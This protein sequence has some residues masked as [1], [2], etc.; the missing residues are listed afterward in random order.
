MFPLLKDRKFLRATALLVGTMVGVGIFGIPFAFAKAGFWLG[1]AWLLG[2]TALTML[3]NL[4]FAELTLRTQG[5]H[6]MAGYANIYLGPWARRLTFFALVLSGY[7]TLLAY[8]IIV[9][10]FLHNV[11]SQ[12]IAINP[13]LYGV[14]FA[15]VWSLV[16]FA[17]LRTVASVDLFMMCAFGAVILLVF[18]FGIPNINPV[19]LQGVIWDFWFLPYGVIM[20][21]LAGANT[22]PLQRQLLAGRERILRPAI[23]TAVALV[24][25]LY[26]VFAFTVVGISGDITTPDALGG[27]FGFLGSGVILLGSVFGIMTISTSFLMMSEALYETFH[28]DYRVR[29]LW[30]W[31][32]VIG[33]PMLFFWSG[34]RNF[35]DVIGLVGA[36]AVG[37]LSIIVLLAYLRGRSY[38]LR[39][40]EFTVPVPG[41]VVWMI[42]ALFAA[43]IVYTVVV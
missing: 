26:L 37:I 42:V 19:N 11:L 10:G 9:G 39:E 15:G 3:Y 8:M 21:A 36:V 34:L 38:R 18:I 43:G 35:I 33:P 41:F 31:A 4:M 16:V 2:L 24:G 5:V 14:I 22:I 28:I 7:G 40:P 32:L 1:A 13:D 30:A 29:P 23:M 12:Y 20:F 25:I 6:H 27:L 17:R